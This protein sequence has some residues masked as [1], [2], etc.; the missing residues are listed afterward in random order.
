MNNQQSATSNEESGDGQS[1]ELQVGTCTHARDDGFAEIDDEVAILA[2]VAAEKEANQ[3]QTEEPNKEN[4]NNNKNNN[5]NSNT[6]NCPSCGIDLNSFL[7]A[8]DEHREEEI[9]DDK[10][11]DGTNMGKISNHRISQREKK[12]KREYQE[13]ATM[14]MRQTTM[15]GTK[16]FTFPDDCIVCAWRARNPGAP[17]KNAPH[18]PHHNHCPRKKHP[19]DP[20]RVRE[21]ERLKRMRLPVQPH[22]KLIGIRNHPDPQAA[23]THFFEPRQR[24]ATVVRSRLPTPPPSDGSPQAGNPV[25][26]A[27]SVV[28]PPAASATASSPSAAEPRQTVEEW[29][30]QEEG[31]VDWHKTVA[32][33]IKD[34][35]FVAKLNKEKIPLPIKVVA[36]VVSE[37]VFPKRVPVTNGSMSQVVAAKLEHARRYFDANNCALKMPKVP[38]NMEPIDKWYHMIEGQSLVACCWDINFPFLKLKCPESHCDGELKRERTNWSENKKLLPLFCLDGPPMWVM[39]MKYKCVKCCVPVN[40]NDGRVLRSLP[41]YVRQTYPVDPIY[42]GDGGKPQL[43]RN[44]T[45]LFP[46]MMHTYGNGEL[47]SQLI[48]GAINTSYERRCGEFMNYHKHVRRRQLELQQKGEL[49]QG[50]QPHQVSEYPSNPADY[51]PKR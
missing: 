4:N 43:H 17:G 11:N 47:F 31:V 32:A 39:V 18:R 23:L 3:Q 38:R 15:Q 40:A 21:E 34:A 5:T 2:V 6:T 14:N 30:I 20:D 9:R 29:T 27:A 16:T 50:V 42:A 46:K 48:Y 22:E 41:Y 12:R 36:Q 8:H 37:E 35:A 1:T 25:T 24:T 28:S 49:P 45:D 19:K 33:K 7:K 51:C 13:Y 44:I 26:A 10:G